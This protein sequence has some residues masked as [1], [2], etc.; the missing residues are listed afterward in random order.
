MKW[1]DSENNRAEMG[2]SSG[3]PE[4][5]AG[6][7]LGLRRAMA[8]LGLIEPRQTASRPDYALP[9]VEDPMSDADTTVPQSL[10]LDGHESRHQRLRRAAD[11]LLER[12]GQLSWEEFAKAAA[13]D[14]ELNPEDRHALLDPD[15]RELTNDA[16]RSVSLDDKSREEIAALAS[17]ACEE[18]VKSRAKLK[19]SRNLLVSVPV[20]PGEFAR[21]HN[22]EVRY[23]PIS[24]DASR[25]AIQADFASDGDAQSVEAYVAGYIVF[26]P[27]LAPRIKIE[28][29]EPED[30][31]RFT[32][33][34][35]LGHFAQMKI[36]DKTKRGFYFVDYRT[37]H[38]D[39]AKVPRSDAFANEFAHRLLVPRS[40]LRMLLR[41]DLS[42]AQIRD[43]LGVSSLTII[44][45]LADVSASVR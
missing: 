44:H 24:N 7:K 43:F 20:D 15:D 30:S 14:Q 40:V 39:G 35:E 22:L 26:E 31:Q 3:A 6:R 27:G 23:G 41:N 29:R 4:Q 17:Q 16:Q 33:A 2:G 28:N 5:T 25:E 37:R 13:A 34:H 1:Q 9:A 32:L 8:W 42:V 38:L 12:H 36:L 21:A 18:F 11:E 10:D 19:F 45:N